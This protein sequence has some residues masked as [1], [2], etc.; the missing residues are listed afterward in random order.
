MSRE[1]TEFSVMI[2][3]HFEPIEINNEESF[4]DLILIFFI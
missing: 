1:L 4:W 2:D 3:E